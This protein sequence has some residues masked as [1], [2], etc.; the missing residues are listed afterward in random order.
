MDLYHA[1]VNVLRLS[2]LLT[3]IFSETYLRGAATMALII[4]VRTLIDL[5]LVS[6]DSIAHP[7][8]A[9]V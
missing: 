7:A 5:R 4:V 8:G 3:G 9:R 6:I 1:I 2:L